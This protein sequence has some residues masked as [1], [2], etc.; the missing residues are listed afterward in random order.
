MSEQIAYFGMIPTTSLQQI[1]GVVGNK[2]DPHITILNASP[3]RSKTEEVDKPSVIPYCTFRKMTQISLELS[4]DYSKVLALFDT[5][6]VL[7]SM[8]EHGIDDCFIQ[9]M[10]LKFDLRPKANMI[11]DLAFKTKGVSGD[12]ASF[13]MAKRYDHLRRFGNLQ[14]PRDKKTRR[15]K[16]G[17]RSVAVPNQ[18][19]LVEA[20]ENGYPVTTNQMTSLNFLKQIQEMTFGLVL[21][22]KCVASVRQRYVDVELLDG[23]Y[24]GVWGAVE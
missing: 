7:S 4:Y 2:L 5:E 16:K 15:F 10:G 23:T 19:E 12:I 22:K 17:T 14:I 8:V 6:E 24:R 3:R 21:V 20:K 18:L 1:Y 13:V 9:L 11:Y